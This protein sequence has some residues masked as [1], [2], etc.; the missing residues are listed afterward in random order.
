MY[1]HN[2]HHH[3]HHH[4]HGFNH[5]HHSQHGTSYSNGSYTNT[6][7]GTEMTPTNRPHGNYDLASNDVTSIGQNFMTNNGHFGSTNDQI[8][9]YEDP[10]TSFNGQ[11]EPKSSCTAYSTRDNEL[12]QLE[13]DQFK[14]YILHERR[15]LKKIS[16]KTNQICRIF[17]LNTVKSLFWTL[18]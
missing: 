16:V 6:T 9:S 18:F 10:G 12:S 1:V 14:R 2:N 5:H 11:H 13:N 15:K 8:P 7:G 4:S 3:H 17:S